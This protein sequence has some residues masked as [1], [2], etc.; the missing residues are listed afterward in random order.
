M[1]L[2]DEN[3]LLKLKNFK[4]NTVFQREMIGLMVQAFNDAK[5]LRRVNSMFMAIDLDFSGTLSFTKIKK[6]FSDFGQE[7]SDKEV[8]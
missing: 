4:Y 8:E 3:A 6:L 7:L 1:S 2:I 5:E